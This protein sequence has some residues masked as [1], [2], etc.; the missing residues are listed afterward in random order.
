[1]KTSKGRPQE[2][3]WTPEMDKELLRVSKFLKGKALG[4]HFGLSRP[5]CTNRL[6]KLRGPSKGVKNVTANKKGNPSPRV[7]ADEAVKANI[8]AVEDKRRGFSV[9]A[10]RMTQYINL[11]KTGLPIAD[12]RKRLGL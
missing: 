11:L 6:R 8:R 1:M 10:D 4:D 9:P 2:S 3:F 12:A 7:N 5:Y